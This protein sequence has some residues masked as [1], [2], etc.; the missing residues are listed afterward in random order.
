MIL[1]LFDDEAAEIGLRL[2]VNDKCNDTL[3]PIGE[4]GCELAINNVRRK[5]HES[6]I[7]LQWDKTEFQFKIDRGNSGCIGGH[8]R[9]FRQNT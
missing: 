9:I 4:K 3:R 5:L 6:N 1:N 2:I 8:R 7:A